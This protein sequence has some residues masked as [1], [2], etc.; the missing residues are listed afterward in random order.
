MNDASPI[1]KQVVLVGAGNAHLVFL[2]RWRMSPWPGVAVTLVSEFADVPYSAMVPGHIAGDYRWD[3]ITLDLVRFCRSVGVRFV[4]ARVTGVDAAR[5]LVQIEDHA[6]ISYDVL[7]LGL[8]SLPAAPEG[9][10]NGEWSFSMRPLGLFARQLERLEESL[11][12][13][14][15]AF[16]LVVVGGGASGCELALAIQ[17]RLSKSSGFRLTLLQANRQL[18]P[19][20]AD[21]ASRLMTQRLRDAGIDVRLEACVVGGGPDRL[22]LSRGTEIPCDGVLWATPASPPACLRDSG[23]SIDEA[24]FLRVG[25]TLQSLGDQAVFGTGD[26]V[27]F[28]PRPSL[29]RNGVHAVRQGRVLFD[30]VREFLHERPL[31]PFRPQRNCLCLLN[32]GDGEAILNYGSFATKGRF[33]R[34]LKNRIDRAWLE[35]FDV[36]TRSVSEGRESDVTR[37]VSEGRESDVTRSVSEGR[38]DI[39]ETTPSLT[40]RVTMDRRQHLMRCGGCGAKVSGDVLSSV[41]K[42]LEIPD[43]PRVLLGTRSGEDAAVHRVRADLFGIAADKLVEVQ[44]VDYFRAFIDDPYLFGRIAALHSVSDVY[45]MNARPFSALAIATL[46]YARGPIQAAQLRELLAGA[47][48]SLNE[49][50]VVL[51]GGHTSEGHD[52]SLGFAVTGYADEDQLFRKSNLKPGDT[53]ILTKPLGTGAILAAWMHGACS[54]AE[55]A[56]VIEQALIANASAAAVFAQFGARA[57]TDITGFGLAGHLLEML[58]ASRVSARLTMTVPVLSGFSAAVAQGILS[59]LH[60]ENAKLACRVHGSESP[61]EWLFDPQTSGGLL[62]AIRPEVASAVVEEL[63][64]RGLTRAAAIGQVLDS[65]ATPV[66]ELGPSSQFGK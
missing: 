49:L 22:R 65:T 9:C 18:L 25:E 53:L 63:H 31:T 45:A 16:Q 42:G 61:P 30:N 5:R 48:R 47:T 12:Q 44:T 10:A 21:R 1:E 43:D 62:G 6:A 14:P 64:R 29:P 3:E 7:S 11:Q 26:C 13:T 66:I 58:D 46:P 51:T 37:S 39:G 55:F 38:S 2:R 59:T 20:F 52:L 57:V 32:T 15:R 27:T 54:A 36:I 50:G 28:T 24:N 56:E 34:S 8:G 23:L 33:V 17:R 40:R 35:S 60:P 4:A 41:L 19:G